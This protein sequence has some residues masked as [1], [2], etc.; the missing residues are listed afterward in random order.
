VQIVHD[1]GTRPGASTLHRVG[2]LSKYWLPLVFICIGGCTVLRAQSAVRGDPRPTLSIGVVIDTHP[3]PRDV[4]AFARQVVD[5]L[6]NALAGVAEETFVVR[7]S[8]RVQ[9]VGGWS[10]TALGLTTASASLALDNQAGGSR[11]AVLNDGLMDALTRLG[12]SSNGDRHGL[13]VIGEGND[14]GSTARFSSIL[15]TA[16]AGHVQCFALL[17]A[18]HRS[19][20][21][22]VRQFGFNLYRLASATKGKAYDVRTNPESLDKAIHDMVKRL[23]SPIHS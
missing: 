20:V 2:A 5:S 10:P 14:S 1:V 23:T 9:L 4:M 11:G 21:G 19:Q 15:A 7:Y 8:D 18:N 3:Q 17:V 16:K 6:S 12:S 22:R 13:I